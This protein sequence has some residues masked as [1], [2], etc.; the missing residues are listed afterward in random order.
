MCPERIL[1]K[2]R[3]ARLKPLIT[4][5][6]NS[7]TIRKGAIGAGTPEGK[8]P[9]KKTSLY[10][11]TVIKNTPPKKVTDKKNGSTSKLVTAYENGSMPTKLDNKINKKR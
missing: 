6:T 9:A 11:L 2:S 7:I 5:E 10:F 3:I 4:Y 8:K 1:A